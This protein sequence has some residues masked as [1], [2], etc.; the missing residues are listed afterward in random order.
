M[1]CMHAFELETFWYQ[2]QWLVDIAKENWYIE[3]DLLD[4]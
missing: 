3:D 1:F 4:T 2:I